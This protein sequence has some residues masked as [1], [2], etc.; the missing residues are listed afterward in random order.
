MLC[1]QLYNYNIDCLKV[2]FQ[3]LR[4]FEKKTKKRRR[5]I[6][7]AIHLPTVQLDTVQTRASSDTKSYSNLA[8][9]PYVLY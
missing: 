2:S 8:L 6:W 9:L 4:P 3:I 1:I 7:H 5:I